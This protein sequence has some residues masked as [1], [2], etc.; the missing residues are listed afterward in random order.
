MS[1]LKDKSFE[2][3]QS[4]EKREK[5]SAGNPKELIIDHQKNQHTHYKSWKKRR[6]RSRN[7]HPDS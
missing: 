6:Q 7:R 2:I 5:K 3:I 1:K 4:E